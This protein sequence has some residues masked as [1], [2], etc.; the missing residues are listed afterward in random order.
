[1]RVGVGRGALAV[2]ARQGRA[3]DDAALILV[4]GVRIVAE[5]R[6]VGH[7]R[8]CRP[9]GGQVVERESG[10]WAP[11]RRGSSRRGK[12]V[13]ITNGAA[14]GCSSRGAWL[15]EPWRGESRA[16]LR[17]SEIEQARFAALIGARAAT[18][19]LETVSDTAPRDC[20]CWGGRG[21]RLVSRAAR[22]EVERAGH[23]TGGC[24]GG[25]GCSACGR[26]AGRTAATGSP[27]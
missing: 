23:G 11:R 3:L 2:L 16:L 14:V 10:R 20:S 5:G 4:V 12:L 17:R 21:E 19:R 18:R 25:V 1:M 27:E 9:R 22:G 6:L 15:R 8:G 7:D 24:A 26:E 13:V